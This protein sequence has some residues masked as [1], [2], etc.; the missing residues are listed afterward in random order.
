MTAG[1]TSVMPTGGLVFG[2]TSS[3]NG[4]TIDPNTGA[5]QWT[6]ADYGSYPITVGEGKRGQAHIVPDPPARGRHRL[7]E[8]D[9][10]R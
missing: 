9:D 8:C 1:I 10:K 5:L 2:L 3:P 6:P 4:M 7:R